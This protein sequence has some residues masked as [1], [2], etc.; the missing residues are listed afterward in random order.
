M[1]IKGHRHLLT[2]ALHMQH[3]KSLQE[4]DNSLDGWMAEFHTLLTFEAALPPEK[5]SEK[6]TDLDALKAAVAANINL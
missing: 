2:H 5:D 1:G 4:F 6:E 3:C